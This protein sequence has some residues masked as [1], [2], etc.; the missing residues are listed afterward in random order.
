MPPH[1]LPLSLISPLRGGG[2]GKERDS[3]VFEFYVSIEY[4]VKKQVKKV[5]KSPLS[6]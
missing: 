6:T 4:T 1:P 3:I 2:E 5:L